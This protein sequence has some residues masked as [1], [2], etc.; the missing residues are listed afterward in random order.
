MKKRVALFLTAAL[1]LSTVGSPMAGELLP[2]EVPVQEELSAENVL[3]EEELPGEIALEEAVPAVAAEE[4]VPAEAAV[5]AVPIE[6]A[7]EAAPAEAAEEIIP[8]EELPAGELLEQPTEDSLIP[9]DS[10]E[11]ELAIE[12]I[13]TIT[14]EIPA[15]EIEDAPSDIEGILGEEEPALAGASSGKCGTNV[16][17]TLDDDGIL[18]IS[19][20]GDMWDWTSPG[21]LTPWYES[22]SQIESITIESGVKSI[23]NYAFSN[24]DALTAVT[25]GDSVTSMGD[26]AFYNCSSLASITFE[27]DAP[28]F[29]C[30]GGHTYSSS[31]EFVIATAYYPASNST[32]TAEVR[33]DYGGDI[34]WKTFGLVSGEITA[35]DFVKTASTSV[36]TFPIGATRLGTG[37]LTYS[38]D[39]GEVMV[40]DAGTVVIQPNYVGKATITIK[41]AAS[42]AYTAATKKITVTV[43]K[44]E[45]KIIAED[46]TFKADAS[47][48]QTKNIVVKSQLGEG[49]LTYVS[50][51]TLIKVDSNGKVTIPANYVGTSTITIN[52]AASGIYD[53]ATTSIK[54]TVNRI[55]GKILAEDIMMDASAQD[56]IKTIV[57]TSQLGKGNRTYSSDNPMITIDSAGKVK[58]AKYFA[59][60]ATVTID[61]AAEGIYEPAS[62]TIKVTVNKIN[63]KINASNFIKYAAPVEKSF[64]IGAARLGPGK[65]TYKSNSARV[66]VDSTGKVTI[67][68]NYSGIVTIRIYVEGASIYKAASKTIT[69]TVR[70][71]IPSITSVTNWAPGTITARWARYWSATG[72]ILQIATNSKFTTGIKNVVLSDNGLRNEDVYG[73]TK[74]KTYY[75]R[76]RTYKV[77]GDKTLYSSW[78]T[79]V[80][81]K[82]SK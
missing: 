70:P 21:A 52:S 67:P 46:L 41:A 6:A 64:Y 34:T 2:D 76:L 68:R 1:T 9:E 50:S 31:F 74:G 12:P 25:I 81:V 19:G 13:E 36:Q 72:Y 75:L 47:K 17:W 29:E 3:A 5:E 38:S 27:G 55:A 56:Q 14:E 32:W 42:G 63:G 23:G 26:Y 16:S 60:T 49:K 15:E 78:S 28:V 61:A 7:E 82:I 80:T 66:T 11:E 8:E 59:G 39:T 43:N 62:T 37:K 79:P 20:T 53:A 10:F 22:K 51:N 18:T 40:D 48:T 77:A 44:K 73:L 57:V 71:Q 4:A 54:V 58:I 65:L 24:C 69:V 35:S 45:G 33:K 30:S